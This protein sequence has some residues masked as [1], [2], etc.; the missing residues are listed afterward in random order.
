MGMDI[1]V[2]CTRS[3]W[4]V[5]KKCNNKKYKREYEAQ[6]LHPLPICLYEVPEEELVFRH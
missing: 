3:K 1:Y 5:L 6:Y 4:G 2:C